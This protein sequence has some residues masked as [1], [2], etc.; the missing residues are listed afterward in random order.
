MNC[1]CTQAA[2]V[3]GCG[4]ASGLVGVVAYIHAISK[5]MPRGLVCCPC[6]V[7]GCMVAPASMA[8]QL[9]GPVNQQPATVET[10]VRLA[11]CSPLT[12]LP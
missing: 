11:L 2:T 6:Q 3:G 7:V 9:T 8:D 4:V 10:K 1:V 12:M 5:P